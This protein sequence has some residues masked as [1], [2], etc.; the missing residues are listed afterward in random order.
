MR[1]NYHS[2]CFARVYL[3]LLLQ[4]IAGVFLNKIIKTS[5]MGGGGGA[6]EMVGWCDG[7]A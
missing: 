7:A 4:D 6:G 3:K 5:L 2:V 1:R